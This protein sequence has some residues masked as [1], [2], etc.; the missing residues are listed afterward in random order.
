MTAYVIVDVTVTDPDAYRDYTSAVPGTLDPFEGRFIVRG[1]AYETL[2]GDWQPQRIV[3]LEFPSV[4]RATA[5][6]GS[7]AYQAILPIRQQHADTR[8]LTVVE[9]VEP[10]ATPTAN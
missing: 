8:F 3:I 5:W 9:G 7:P 10:A 1:G 6:H 2:E 4:E